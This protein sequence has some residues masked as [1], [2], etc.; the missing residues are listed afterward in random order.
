MFLPDAAVLQQRLPADV[1]QQMAQEFDTIY[2]PAVRCKPGSTGCW[3]D[4]GRPDRAVRV[5][6]RQHLA[7]ERRLAGG[8]GARFFRPG[9]AAARIHQRAQLQLVQ[10]R[11]RRA[12]CR[13][14]P[15]FLDGVQ[16]L[17]S[18]HAVVRDGAP[19]GGFCRR[20]NCAGAARS[21]GKARRSISPRWPGGGC[22]TIEPADAGRR[23]FGIAITPDTLAMDVKP[24]WTR[25]VQRIW[26]S[27]LS[28]ESAV[29]ALLVAAC[30]RQSTASSSAGDFD[31]ARGCW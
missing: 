21:C 31:C 12:P 20:A 15:P 28:P 4:Q 30:Q 29:L 13:P 26:P 23:V 27:I 6:R 25:A 3:Q 11:A 2:P 9:L 19:A 10:R 24:P 18:R 22:R 5:F 14:R 7:Q 16:A 8:D 1:Y 17:A